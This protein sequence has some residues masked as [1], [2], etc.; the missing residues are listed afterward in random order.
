MKIKFKDS[1][2]AALLF[3]LSVPCGP[4]VILWIL[5]NLS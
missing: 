5:Q 3:A 2:F 1:A 4:L